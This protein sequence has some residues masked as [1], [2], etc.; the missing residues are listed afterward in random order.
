MG[1]GVGAM[2]HT[3]AQKDLS[4]VEFSLLLWAQWMELTLSG[5]VASVFTSCACHLP[6][7]FL[8]KCKI[9]LAYQKGSKIFAEQIY[10]MYIKTAGVG[11]AVNARSQL[12]RSRIRMSFR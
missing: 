7:L 1:L 10:Q 12:W 5:L 8:F 2:A 6:P 4:G 3:Q 9:V 11:T